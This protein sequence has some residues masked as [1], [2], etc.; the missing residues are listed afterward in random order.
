MIHTYFIINLVII[1]IGNEFLKKKLTDDDQN[2]VCYKHKKWNRFKIP[3][4]R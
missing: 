3:L 2:R 4:S 1:M